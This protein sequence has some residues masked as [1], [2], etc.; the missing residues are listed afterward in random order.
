MQKLQVER[1]CQRYDRLLRFCFIGWIVFSIFGLALYPLLVRST[2]PVEVLK[3]YQPNP[4]PYNDIRITPDI[5][6]KAEFIVLDRVT[7]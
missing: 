1:T 4:K 2:E 5:V 6:E 3:T 7:E